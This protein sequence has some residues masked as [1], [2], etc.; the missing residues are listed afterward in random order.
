VFL[1]MI[2]IGVLGLIL[3]KVLIEIER[4]LLRW[5]VVPT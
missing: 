3:N 5:R 2:L 1:G 4:R